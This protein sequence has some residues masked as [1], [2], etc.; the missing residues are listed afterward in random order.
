MLKAAA[1]TAKQAAHT[2]VERAAASAPA[3]ILQPEIAGAAGLGPARAA[4]EEAVAAEKPVAVEKSVAVEKPVA[5]EK[6]V[7]TEACDVKCE[8]CLS[9]LKIQTDLRTHLSSKHGMTITQLREFPVWQECEWCSSLIKQ[10]SAKKK[11][12]CEEYKRGLAA[13]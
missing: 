7:D 1:Y 12:N 4:A 8:P 6:P 5:A 3:P 2:A 9:F 13:G 10:Y 11:H